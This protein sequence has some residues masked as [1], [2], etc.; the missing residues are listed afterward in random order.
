MKEEDKLTAG[1]A[2]I[3]GEVITKK[4]NEGI[5]LLGKYRTQR[6]TYSLRAVPLC[7]TCGSTMHACETGDPGCLHCNNWKCTFTV[8]MWENG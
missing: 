8:R 2:R 7:P 6:L 5:V 4:Q 3:I 1:F